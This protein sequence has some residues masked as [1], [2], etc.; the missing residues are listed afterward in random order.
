VTDYQDYHRADYETGR[1]AE[2]A[3]P[4]RNGGTYSTTRSLNDTRHRTTGL[5]PTSLDHPDLRFMLQLLAPD[6]AAMYRTD[7][8]GAEVVHLH[9]DDGSW[10]ETATTAVTRSPRSAPAPSG[11]RPNRQPDSGATTTDRP[12]SRFGLTVTTDGTQRVWL[13]DP[14]TPLLPD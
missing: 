13:G 11:Q 14:F 10:A 9:T 3:N 4:L 8:D 2:A 1:R 6:I 5:D 12:P 7:N